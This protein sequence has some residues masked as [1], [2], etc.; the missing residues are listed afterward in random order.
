MATFKWA[1]PASIAT[2][3]SSDLNSL[4]DGANAISASQSNDATGELYLYG[5][6]EMYIAATSTRASDARIEMYFLIE[7]DGTNYSYGGTSV[8]PAP[9][10]HVGDFQ[11][12]ATTSA[13][14]T[15][16]RGIL[17]PPADFKVLLIN[18]VGVALASSG[19]TLKWVKYNLQTA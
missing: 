12:D 16:L 15:H 3:L 9:N 11:F 1:T 8:D 17:L 10:T 6:F 14:Y 2:I 18:E 7:I 13:Q 19:N 4:G 5:D